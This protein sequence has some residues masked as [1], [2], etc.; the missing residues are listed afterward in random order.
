MMVRFSSIIQ[1]TNRIDTH[2]LQKDCVSGE[3]LLKTIRL[4]SFHKNGIVN[5]FLS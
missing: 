2:W 1:V 4:D 3:T 5:S